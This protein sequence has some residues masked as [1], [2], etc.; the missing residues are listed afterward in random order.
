MFAFIQR[1]LTPKPKQPDFDN[2][3]AIS[4]TNPLRVQV[5]ENKQKIK[6]V[7]VGKPLEVHTIS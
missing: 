3:N 4:T 5:W 6:N 7:T 2:V 1:I